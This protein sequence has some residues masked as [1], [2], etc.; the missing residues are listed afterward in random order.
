MLVLVYIVIITGIPGFFV[1]LPLVK[2]L[3]ENNMLPFPVPFMKKGAPSS[4]A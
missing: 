4:K 3:N 2:Y 1:T